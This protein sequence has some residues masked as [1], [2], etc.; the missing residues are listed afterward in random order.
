MRP[1]PPKSHLHR[2]LDPDTLPRGFL[3]GGLHVGVK[4]SVALSSSSAGDGSPP[5]SGPPDVS[6]FVSTTPAAQT[7]S[8]ALFTANSVRAAPVV[9]SESVLQK[10]LG[11]V[12]TVVVNSGCANAVTGEK[13]M[14]DAWSMARVAGSVVGDGEEALVMS[15][16][17]I[18]KHLPIERILQGI[19]KLKV[20]V[21]DASSSL[22]G[23]TPSH[24]DAASRGL[25]TTDTFPKLRSRVFTL[26]GKEYRI[27]GMDKGAGMIHPNMV[28]PPFSPNGTATSNTW[29]G[30]SKSG[31]SLHATLLG[32]ILTDVRITPASLQSALDYAVQRSFNSISVD[33]DMSTNDTII[34]MASGAGG[35]LPT[36][37]SAKPTEVYNPD[38]VP[39][40][41]S[42]N[43]TNA[44]ACAKGNE[45]DELEIDEK[46]TP[47]LYTAFRSELTSFAIELAQLVVRDGEGATK[48]VSIRVKVSETCGGIKPVHDNHSKL[49]GR[50]NVYRCTC[51]CIAHCNKCTR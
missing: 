24:Y 2:P 33:G 29:E 21:S 20:S 10:T 30:L 48:F 11:R 17:V 14:K 6:L 3:V 49:T 46:Q 51:Y 18:G 12:R 8:A 45:A 28:S 22:L 15:T 41:A 23:S 19:E 50:A 35:T 9:V 44:Q 32:I 27:A 4:K 39:A 38:D 13:G 42:Q 1:I 47:D 36:A 34:C 37:T 26:G 43:V 16:G 31:K 5:P 25:L 40:A 7:S